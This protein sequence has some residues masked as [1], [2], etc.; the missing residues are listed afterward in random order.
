MTF[1]VA[2]L[3]H[4]TGIVVQ[5]PSTIWMR[6]VFVKNGIYVRQEF[7]LEDIFK[8]KKKYLRLGQLFRLNHKRVRISSSDDNNVPGQMAILP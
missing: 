1:H 2:Q 6:V 5:N 7:I 4:V 3:K 8:I